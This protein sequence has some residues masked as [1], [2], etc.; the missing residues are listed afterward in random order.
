MAL[1]GSVGAK[2]AKLRLILCRLLIEQGLVVRRS[3]LVLGTFVVRF[4]LRIPLHRPAVGEECNGIVPLES[5]SLAV[6]VEQVLSLGETR[7]CAEH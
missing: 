2:A 1:A 6:Q 3:E 4:K 7:N 5:D